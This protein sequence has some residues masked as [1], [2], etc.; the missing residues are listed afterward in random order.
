[1]NGWLISDVEVNRLMYLPHLAQILYTTILRRHMDFQSGT[2]GITYRLSE[3]A[4]VERLEVHRP[5]GSTKP[6]YRPTRQTIRSALEQLIRAGLI[7]KLPQKFSFKLPCAIFGKNRSN[8]EQPQQQ[9]ESETYPQPLQPSEFKAPVT[10]SQ[11][12]NPSTTDQEQPQQQPTSGKDINTNN[13]QPGAFKMHRE[14]Q[15]SD[16]FFQ[17]LKKTGLQLDPAVL[18]GFCLFW[19][20]PENARRQCSQNEWEWKLLEQIKYKDRVNARMRNNPNN[21]KRQQPTK[22]GEIQ[23]SPAWQLFKRNPAGE[24]TGTMES[25]GKPATADHGS[26]YLQEIRKKLWG[27]RG[28]HGK[29]QETADRGKENQNG[30]LLIRDVKTGLETMKN[31]VT[32][33]AY[34]GSKRE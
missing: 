21:L 1:M 7:E 33:S 23:Y 12:E 20:A 30:Q 18:L 25:T 22:P 14:W 11:P 26:R 15:P 2:V 34:S 8:E 4:M 16:R 29:Q 27:D 13:D 31:R 9:P 3:R 32:L 6:H 19:T 5:R 10:E 24:K 17:D 28:Q